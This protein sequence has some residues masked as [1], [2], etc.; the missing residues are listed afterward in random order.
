[1]QMLGGPSQHGERDG[2]II[3][4]PGWTVI[5]HPAV[6]LLGF[7][8]HKLLTSAYTIRTTG[9]ADPLVAQ[10]GEQE[11]EQIG[12]ANVID[13][14]NAIFD[15]PLFPRRAIARRTNVYANDATTERV[16]QRF[17]IGG[18]SA[19]ISDDQTITIVKLINR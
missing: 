18:I 14:Y 13:R 15:A 16:E 9:K 7:E 2:K 6:A 3:M 10:L 17:A 19:Q 5:D 4:L 12:P 1:M 8:C 11:F